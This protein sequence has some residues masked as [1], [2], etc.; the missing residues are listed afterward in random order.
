MADPSE[1]FEHVCQHVRETTKLEHVKELLEWDERTLMPVAAGEYRADQIT[2]LAGLVHQRATDPRL[3][4]WLEALAESPLA[5]DPNSDQGATI[6]GLK[7]EYDRETKLPQTLV[8]AF[9]RARVLGQ[10]AWVKA[11]EA[12]DFSQFAP[13]LEKII[14]LCREMAAALGAVEQPYD[15]LLDYFEPGAKT[16][17]V[18]QVLDR[19]KKLLVPLVEEIRDSP[20]RPNV[21]VLKRSF[22][23]AAQEKIGKLAASKIGFNFQA[24]RL[25][26]THHPFCCTVGPNDCRITTRYDEHFFP[27]AFFSTLH[28]AGHGIYEQGLRTDWHGL[29]PGKYA[30]L[31]IHESQSRLWENMVGRSYAFWRHLY[32]EAKKL[33]PKALG[34][35]P[36]GDFHFAVNEVTPS[37]IRVEADEVTYNLHIIA[38]F[39]LEQA[40]LSGDLKVADLPSAWNEKYQQQLGIQPTNDADGCLQDVHWS[41]GLLGYFPTYSLGN[42]YAGQLM[43]QAREELGDLEGMFAEGQFVPLL[44]WLR[45]NVHQVGQCRPADQLVE[46]ICG[47]SINPEPMVKYLRA[48]LGPLYGIQH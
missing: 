6:R 2:L 19:L 33:F 23:V 4:E 8:E 45:E 31:G 34:D 36:V 48:K 9:S 21:E 25:D 44:D 28:E 13:S 14:T 20:R 27:S 43:E 12:D 42:I 47:E 39:E 10:Q 18:T 22:S 37:L 26:V 38:R 17:Q 41:A 35:M 1:I 5:A 3:G 40:L 11:R 32:P 16:E 46:G 7:R 24:G 15:A 30:S 29:P